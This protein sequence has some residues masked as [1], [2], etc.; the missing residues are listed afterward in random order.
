VSQ[1]ASS[2]PI[3]VLLRRLIEQYGPSPIEFVQALGYHKNERGLG[4]LQPWLESG[5][6]F[7]RIIEQI[8]TVYPAVAAELKLAVE[9]TDAIRQA[10]SQAAFLE[11]CKAEAATFVP[12][13]H[14]EGQ[15]TVPNGICIFGVSG[16][17]RRWTTIEIP[18]AMLDLPVDDLLAAAPELMRAYKLL[19]NGAVPFFAMLTGFKLVRLVDYYQFDQDGNFIEHVEK[20]F[21]RGRVTVW[22]T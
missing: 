19:Y 14:A 8:A 15:K 13:I 20:P 6:G 18:K 2:Y 1:G 12:F 7:G 5:N 17:F 16:G 4:R 3:S 21:R 11:Q 22:L 9:A 10:E